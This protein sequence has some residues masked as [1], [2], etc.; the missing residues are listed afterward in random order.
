[1]PK[2]KTFAVTHRAVDLLL[3]RVAVRRMNPR[4]DKFHCR[5]RIRIALKDSEG[6]VRPK[7]FPAGKLPSEAAGGADSLGFGKI[8][9]A[10]SQ[11]LLRTITFN[12]NPDEVRR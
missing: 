7:Y 11:G 6:L 10:P 3:H 4:E 2:I 5:F 8:S 1:M 9:F 12:R